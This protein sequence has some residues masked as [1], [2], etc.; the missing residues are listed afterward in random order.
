LFSQRPR[1]R[2]TGL[3]I[4]IGLAAI[5]G[6]SLVAG[7]LRT[8]NRDLVLYLDEARIVAEDASQQANAYQALMSVQLRELERSEFDV[9][10]QGFETSLAEDQERIAEFR[11]PDKAAAAADM[12]DLA[13]SSWESGLA[14][15]RT[16]ILSVADDPIG[17]A[18]VD[19]LSAALV[20]LQIGDL[21]YSRFLVR[22]TELTVGLDVRVGDFREV[23]FVA[24]E[25]VLRNGVVIAE[26]VRQSAILGTRRDIAILQPVFEPSKTGGQTDDGIDL[27]PATE[28][29][30]FLAVIS[31]NGNQVE[32]GIVVNARF[33][34]ADGAEIASETSE[35]VD[36]EPGAR[37]SVEFSEVAVSPGLRYELRLSMPT[38][39]EEIDIENNSMVIPLVIQAPG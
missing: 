32:K 18:P 35:P 30:G 23:G 33:L 25:P 4:L 3:W 19:S 7:D 2:R 21:L 8:E 11:V 36:L 9:L 37:T 1:R 12:L 28:T 17:T 39:E 29:F 38:V 14:G 6:L 20:E 24:G 34:D 31:N 16:A 5:V 10:M 26:A 27:F 13:M 15:V 22:A